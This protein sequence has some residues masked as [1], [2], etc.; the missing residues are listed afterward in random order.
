MRTLL[1]WKFSPLLTIW[2]ENSHQLEE[3][4]LAISVTVYNYASCQRF[5]SLYCQAIISGLEITIVP[6]LLSRSLVLSQAKCCQCSF[7]STDLIISL[8]SSKL[9]IKA[10]RIMFTFL[11]RT[12][13]ALHDLAFTHKTS[14][15]SC[16][17][18][19]HSPKSYSST[20]F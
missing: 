3:C 2:V 10:C 9:S 16:L 7:K 13:K 11:Q 17:G 18:N 8:A 6:S 5:W 14:V 12:H 4:I 20:Q 19:L 1:I 15:T